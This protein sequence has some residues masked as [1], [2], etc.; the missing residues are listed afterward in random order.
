[1]SSRRFR[2]SGGS[3]C[4]RRPSRPFSWRRRPCPRSPEELRAE[5]GNHNQDRV[6]EVHGPSAAIGQAAIVEHLQQRRRSPGWP[7]R[8]RRTAPQN[9]G[10]G[11][12]PRSAGRPAR[13]PTRSGAARQSGARLG[14][15]H[16][17]GHVDADHGL[18]VGRTGSR[19]ALVAS[20]VLP[21]PVGP[22]TNDPGRFG[23]GRRCRHAN[24][25]RRTR[26][27]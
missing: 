3:S 6:L 4:G 18:L 13:Q 16:V 15:L 24:A 12:R 17:F 1:M 11:A 22:R 10:G 14:L 8:P 25:P 23:S 2:N 5:V 21:T 9:T 7:S 19:R 27:R 26:R 20:S